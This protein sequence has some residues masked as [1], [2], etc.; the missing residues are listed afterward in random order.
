M[1][2]QNEEGD[3]VTHPLA[4]WFAIASVSLSLCT[5]IACACQYALIG[6]YLVF[7]ITASIM[8]ASNAGSTI[9]LLMRKIEVRSYQLRQNWIL[10][11]VFAS[12]T[13]IF[14][15]GLLVQNRCIFGEFEL[16]SSISG[17][18][19]PWKIWLIPAVGISLSSVEIAICFTI[20]RHRGSEIEYVPIP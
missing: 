17:V 18:N 15:V 4:G 3:L 16:E 14:Q 12:L 19:N 9:L 1:N 13:L 8:A 5:M 2:I 6:G 11:I 20:L 7:I 10:C